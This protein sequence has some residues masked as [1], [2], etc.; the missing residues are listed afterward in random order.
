MSLYYVNY[1]F[2]VNCMFSVVSKL[3]WFIK[4]VIFTLYKSLFQAKFVVITFFI[5]S[6][7]PY[8]NMVNGFPCV[9][10]QS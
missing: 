3:V 1:T 4:K 6:H 10:G 5:C 9:V 7:H 2:I 8:S